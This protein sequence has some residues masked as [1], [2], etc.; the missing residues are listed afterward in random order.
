MVMVLPCNENTH[1]IYRWKEHEEENIMRQ[2]NSRNGGAVW[3]KTEGEFFDPKIKLS[4]LS[5]N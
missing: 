3:E 4:N 2:K 1:I 5:H